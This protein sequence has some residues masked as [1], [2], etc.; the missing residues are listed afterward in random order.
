MK[1][2]VLEAFKVRTSQ[3]EM[4]P[5]PGQ[6]ITLPHDKAIR[7]LNEGKI[8]PIERVAYKVYSEI[9]QAYLW[10]VD[11]D[12]DMHSLRSQEVSE[13]IYTADE[14][15]KLKGGEKD[16]LKAI[17]QVKEVFEDSHVDEVIKKRS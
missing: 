2:Q 7:L 6:V 10:I 15:R 17:H 11:T 1:Y 12:Q 4:E 3:G 16:S 8:T 14:I 9:L 13:A 5:Q